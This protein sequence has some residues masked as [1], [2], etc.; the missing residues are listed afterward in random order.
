M[1]CLPGATGR[2]VGAMTTSPTCRLALLLMLALTGASP[3]AADDTA[4]DPAERC[5]SAPDAW[6]RLTAC[7]EI[8]DSA[9]WPGAFAAWAY[10]NR[11]MAHSELGN[12]L[13]AFDDHDKAI[14]LDGSD[15]RAW[16]NR[17]TSHAAFREY[18]RALADYRRALELDPDYV[19]AL[20][21]RA[22][23]FL[24]LGRAAE[25]RA[26]YDRAAGIEGARGADI[27]I[28]EFLRADAS[29]RL[30]DAAASLEDRLNAIAGGAFA[31]TEMR[32]TL[33]ETGYLRA[34]A[35]DDA[36]F[37]AALDRWTQAGCP[38]G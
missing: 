11:A 18:D 4:S 32:R 15:P 28:I 14:E 9:D 27:S 2:N 6:A 38:W 8:I 33:V 5:A 20:L 29:C 34:G 21:N 36:S 17:G 30:G 25:A 7:G 10:S 37:I 26:D 22:S 12:H 35:E 1:A 3:T 16:N 23:L 24:E 13:A 31:R 19:T